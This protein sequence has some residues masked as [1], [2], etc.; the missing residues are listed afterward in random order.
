MYEILL[1]ISQAVKSGVPLSSA[2]RLSLGDQAGQRRCRQSKSFL[3]LATLLDEGIEPKV[4]AAQSGLPNS[5]VQ[6]LDAALTSGDFAGTFDELTKLEIS[7]SLTML[8]V[9]QA[10]AY[11]T[12]LFASTVLVCYQTLFFTIPPFETIFYDFDAMLPP[13]TAGVIQLSHLARSPI[14]LLGSAVA[15]VVLCIAVRFLFPRFWFC[16]P[17]FGTI[18]RRLYEAR[19]L[20][21]LAHQILRNIPLPD[22]FE[23]CGKT[24][25][26]PAYRKDCRSAAEA[27][28]RG[29][30]FWEIALRYYWLFPA[31]LAPILT[32]EQARE[33]LAKNLCRAAETVDQ[34]KD[35]SILFLQV[36]S[37]P[38]Y[39]MFMFTVIGF[40]MTA[41]FMPLVSLVT[42]LT[43]Y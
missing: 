18:G 30:P 3:R 27:A 36:I 35:A 24:F 11:P 14:F 38:V 1:L 10:L 9:L 5:V 34:Q 37:L 29:M 39:V 20:R 23:Q 16:I 26:N 32:V 25:R 43:N 28:R 6:L 13:M 42:T 7:R 31:W 8:R 19:M 40:F 21:Q 22:A 41:M 17:V 4:A 33:S 12:L 2:I 15:V